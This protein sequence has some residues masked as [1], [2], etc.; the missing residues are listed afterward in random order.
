[1]NLAYDF[2]IHTALSP[3]GDTDMTP[4][5]I[6]NMA[7]LKG[8][9]AIAITDHNSTANCEPCIE[10]AR[11]KDIIVIP[12]VELQTKEEIH[13]LCIFKNIKSALD[14]QQIINSRLL[15]NINNPEIFGKQFVFDKYDQIIMEDKKML[16]SAVNI[17]LK[18]ACVM[19]MENGGVLWPAHVDRPSYSII[20][21]LGFIPKE[22]PIKNIEISQHCNMNNFLSKHPQ[23]KR[24]RILRNSDA[25]D[26]QN[27]LERESFIE[28]KDKNIDSIFAAL[29]NLI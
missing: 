7:K 22:L 21:N 18:E 11:G 17:T 28:V 3:C 23:L 8:L 5:N 10:V 2:H 13:M 6:I 27:I 15:N 25:H 9:D 26:L 20:S 1:M 29:N 24:Y 12:G 4:N 16:I 19:V 14:F